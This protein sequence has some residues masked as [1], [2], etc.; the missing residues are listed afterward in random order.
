[1]VVGAAAIEV[2]PPFG[3]LRS[4]VV[5]PSWRGH[6]VGIAL[7]RDRLAW[8]RMRGLVALYLLTTTAPDFFARFGFQA[9]PRVSAPPEIRASREFAELCPD[10]AVLMAIELNA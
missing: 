9:V 4:A 10:T 1:V 3:L 6:G 5:E 2:H 7:T 8:A